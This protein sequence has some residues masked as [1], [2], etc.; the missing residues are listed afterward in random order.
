MKNIYIGLIFVLLAASCS[1]RIDISTGTQTPRLIVNAFVSAEPSQQTVWLAKTAS[2]FGGAPTPAV[3]GA[4]VW[5]DGVELMPN[6]T[7]P[8][9][10]L[11]PVGFHGTEGQPCSLRV[12]CDVNGDGVEEEF[13]A[14]ENMRHNVRLDTLVMVAF[15]L[16]TSKYIPPFTINAV[17]YR[18]ME[19][20]Y[21]SADMYYNSRNLCRGITNYG[22]GEIP[23]GVYGE[24]VVFNLSTGGVAK[25]MGNGDTLQLCP[26]DT[27]RI[28]LYSIPKSTY[29]Y[30]HS[31][32]EEVRGGNPMFSG[33]PANVETNI[34][35]EGAVI[36]CFALRN[37][38]EWRSVILPM[39][40]KTLEGTWTAQ[41]GSGV[42]I[43]INGDS[44]TYI[45]GANS[46]KVYFSG[47]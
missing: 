14:T 5:I 41:D 30:I 22:A 47:V 18:S 10:Y 6:D 2:Y 44:A 11:T 29:T 40:V 4:R 1:E 3:T 9:Q 13:T 33:P 16:D 23:Y 21:F 17:F 12:L 38:S 32:G 34:K 31:A 46:G 24:R 25:D 19:D 45:N 35:G 39:N 42:Q 36:G 20:D 15:G 7:A 28:R 26:F 8:G 37:P 27:L 43:S